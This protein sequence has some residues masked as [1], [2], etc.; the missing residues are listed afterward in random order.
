MFSDLDLWLVRLGLFFGGLL[1]SRLLRGSLGCRVA[2]DRPANRRH[3]P[4]HQRQAY[5]QQDGDDL[6]LG[7]LH[8][9]HDSIDEALLHDTYRSLKFWRPARQPL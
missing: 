3:V 6:S 4:R 5:D 8:A 7:S 9:I 1:C 2:R